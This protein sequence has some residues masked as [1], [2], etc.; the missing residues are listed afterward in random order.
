VIC[1]STR[2]EK[3]QANPPAHNTRLVAS[4]GTL[5]LLPELPGFGS[6]YEIA[7][8]GC[9]Q[10]HQSAPALGQR[11]RD[12]LGFKPPHDENASLR[13]WRTESHGHHISRR[14]ALQLPVFVVIVPPVAKLYSLAE[15]R[16]Q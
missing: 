11:R 5:V 14:G 15:M 7:L 13:L 9:P 10:A 4:S 2:L 8:G 16:T 3:G 1:F 6:L 12:G